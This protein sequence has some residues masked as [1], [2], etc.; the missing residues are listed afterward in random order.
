MCCWPKYI[1]HVAG[2]AIP[3]GDGDIEIAGVIHRD[4]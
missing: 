3:D 1:R 2:I 4:F